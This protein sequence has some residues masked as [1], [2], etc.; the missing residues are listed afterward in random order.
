MGIPGWLFQSHLESLEDIGFILDSNG[1][2][3]MSCV[4]KFCTK[5]GSESLDYQK[6]NLMLYPTEAML[7][8]FQFLLKKF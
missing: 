2:R 8:T 1:I 7:P 3:V 6:L 5:H 4:F